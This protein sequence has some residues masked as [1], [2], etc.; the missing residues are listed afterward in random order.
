MDKAFDTILEIEVG[1]SLVARNGGGR[2]LYRFECSYCGEEVNLAAAKSLLRS[3]HFR[4]RHGNNDTECE[5]YLG[6][7]RDL[8]WESGS[9]K[10]N[11][12]N[13]TLFYHSNNRVFSFG[14]RFSE[15]E[16]K[17]Y[18]QHSASVEILTASPTRIVE[19]KKIN[20]LNFFGD[21]TNYIPVSIYSERYQ[22][23]T[24]TNRQLR[25]FKFLK[26]DDTPTFFKVQGNDD[27]YKAR[28]VSD[29]T[30]FTSV[31]YFAVLHNRMSYP[32]LNR[33]LP[34]KIHIAKHFKFE[35]M[36][37][38]FVG[39]EVII[40]SN[41]REIEDLLHS[42]GYGLEAS[43]TLT[44]LWPPAKYC[45]EKHKIVSEKA[46]VYSS[47]EL[48]AHGNINV[49]SASINKLNGGV[50]AIAVKPNTKIY[51][52]NAEIVIDTDRQENTD[53]ISFSLAMKTAKQ[54]VI[55]DDKS[56]YILF[57]KYGT[58]TL[59]HGQHVWLT[60]SSE[61]KMYD[62]SYLTGRWFLPPATSLTGEL[63]LEDILKHNK[64]EVEFRA[65][66]FLHC[67]LS[68]TVSN[69]L[70]ECSGKKTINAVARQWILEESL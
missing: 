12:E 42:W 48:Q 7:H 50:S 59:K 32:K 53:I 13:T 26:S 31:R 55:P 40:E 2:E 27:N 70:E 46:Y 25:T 3:P 14:I 24:T 29:S 69:Y 34:S 56:Q 1:A 22:I 54:L 57:D 5:N 62:S 19:S 64:H 61:I 38:K 11:R 49:Q 30:L 58:T 52:R 68:V 6:E 44:L 37:R 10:S 47:F 20:H 28:L 43:E 45:D 33:N 39:M 51:R 36:G 15:K 18:E 4:H 21:E 23:R 60:Q 17:E 35:T 8:S 9:R 65:D 41:T 16:I 63:L 67:A 66:D